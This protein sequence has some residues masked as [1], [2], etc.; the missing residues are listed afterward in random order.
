MIHRVEISAQ[1]FGTMRREVKGG[2][3]EFSMAAF[4]AEGGG[5]TLKILEERRTF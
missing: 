5:T 2:V 1:T 3:S 4:G